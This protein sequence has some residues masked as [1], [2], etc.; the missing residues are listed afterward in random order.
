[1]K[2]FEEYLNTIDN[3]DQ[4]IILEDL[5]Q[6]IHTKYPDLVSVVKWNQPMFTHHDTYII[7]FSVSKKHFAV[8][9][10]GKTISLFSKELEENDYDYTKNIIRINWSQIINH[11]L[12][13]KMIEFN[14]E[15]KADYQKFW[16]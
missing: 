8:S 7:G 15:D 6:W 1:M 11:D 14:I 3:E 13:A 4:R 12:L 9:P 16:R 5:L 10:E 2:I